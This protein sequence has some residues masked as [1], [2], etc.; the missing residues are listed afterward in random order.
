MFNS[1]SIT[2][3]FRLRLL[4]FWQAV[5]KID[6]YWQKSLPLAEMISSY[7][8]KQFEYKL[9]KN[10]LL[11]YQMIIEYEPMEGFICCSAFYSPIQN[12][13]SPA[14]FL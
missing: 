5:A 13:I 1:Y 6:S 4:K 14:D 3:N 11:S 8:E 2:L 10:C 9:T 7:S 12:K